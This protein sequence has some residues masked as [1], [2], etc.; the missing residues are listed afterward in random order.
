MRYADKTIEK[1]LDVVRKRIT[2]LE[3]KIEQVY[4]K[5]PADCYGCKADTYADHFREEIYELQE[6]IKAVENIQVLEARIETLEQHIQWKNRAMG[7]AV[8]T[9][10]QC[11][12]R[13]AAN[14]LEGAMAI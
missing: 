12:E 8:T 13:A 9:L 11:S 4:E 2:A 7:R 14:A 10:R 5:Y 3:K 6:Y 1:S